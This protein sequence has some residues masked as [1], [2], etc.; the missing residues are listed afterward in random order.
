MK[1]E[2]KRQDF[3]KAL[4]TTEKI[5]AVKAI[6]DLENSIKL[7]A[8]YDGVTIEATDLKTT[9]KSKVNPESVNLIEP[10]TAVL[11]LA[12]LG[13]M[14]KK[15]KCDTAAIE[16][17]DMKG[18]LIAEGSKTKFPVV[19]AENFPNVPESSGA[20]SI[21]EITSIELSRI[22]TEGI[23][24]SSQPQDFPKYMGSCLLRT[25]ENS[26]KAVST[27]GKRL[28]VSEKFCNVNRQEDILLP[29]TAVRE[30]A[31]QLAAYGDEK[32]RILSD[33]S[34]A[35]FALEN[36]EF[37][38]RRIEANFPEYERILGDETS[39]ALNIS[40]DNLM[41]AVDRV[42]I[43]AKTTTGHIM[44]LD[45]NPES[46]LR[47]TARSPVFGVAAE[48]LEAGITGSKMKVGYNATFFIDGLKALGD[49]DIIIEFSSDEGQ[50]RMKRVDDSSFLYM[51]MPTRL[52]HQDIADDELNDSDSDS[53]SDETQAQNNTSEGEPEF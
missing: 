15:S 49:G 25:T 11:P 26:L 40:C 28:A 24:A 23:S 53:D 44:V 50:T 7:N 16:V 41:S 32:V 22:I 43:I 36:I 12:I 29:T 21:C 30:L 33:N 51:L 39:T 18:T 1:L 31:R 37:S 9:V 34:T 4:Q 3:L 20:E 46:S 38:I 35:W 5:A 48:Y 8:N 13:G 10:G 6:E 14:L 47:I 42:D 52:S 17:K 27:D 45:L 19:P 2:I